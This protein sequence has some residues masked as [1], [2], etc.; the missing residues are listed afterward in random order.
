MTLQQLHYFV[1]ACRYGNISHAAESIGISQPSVSTAIKSLEEEFE[2]RLIKRNQSGFALTEEGKVFLDLATS[3]LDHTYGIANTMMN[4]SK[5]KN[6]LRVGVTS[7]II[8]YFLDEVYDPMGKAHPEI[9]MTIKSAS[10]VS[11]MNDLG[12]DLLDAAVVA[13]TDDL[14]TFCSVIPIKQLEI[15]CC[16]SPNHPFAQKEK[17]TPADLQGEAITLPVSW[18]TLGQQVRQF[19]ENGKAEPKSINLTNDIC[20]IKSMIYQKRSI[21]FLYR[22]IAE[23]DTEMVHIPLGEGIFAQLTLVIKKKS[24]MSEA[25]KIFIGHIKS[26]K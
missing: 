10:G 14:P 23:R 9:E 4:I 13:H 12:N 18:Y 5:K 2:V 19:M 17:I 11:L 1:S 15:V 22:D 3:L 16:V 8:D 25:M 7:T 6:I 20:A 24:Y 21:G 26:N